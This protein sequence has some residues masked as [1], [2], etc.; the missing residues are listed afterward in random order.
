MKNLLLINY[1][2]QIL[3]HFS[4]NF[5]LMLNVAVEM[6]CDL[7]MIDH[8]RDTVRRAMDFLDNIGNYNGNIHQD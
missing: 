1:E 2:R 6:L 4:G 5:I 3:Y 8:D 7:K